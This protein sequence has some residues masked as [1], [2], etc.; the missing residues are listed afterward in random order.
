MILTSQDGRVLTVELDRPQQLN[1]LNSRVLLRLH[2]TI[3][4]AQTDASVGCIVIR[5]AGDRA[6]S[7]G[8]DLDE[9]R[10]LGVVAAQEFIQRGHRTMSS[11]ATSRV[12]VIAHVDGYALGG[13]FELALACHLAVATDRSRFGLPEARIGCMPGFGGTQRL[14]LSV[15]KPVAMHLLLSGEPIDAHRAWQIGLLSIPPLTVDEATAEVARLAHLIA[16]GSRTGLANILDAAH[17]STMPAGCDHEA[18][19][20]ALCIA[21]SDGQEGILSFAERR[22]PIFHEERR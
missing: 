15:S 1:A 4:A 5:G 18:A 21:S 11:V 20:A 3:A 19:L 17:A 12:P 16:S 6:F 7:A 8:A 14:S 22:P 10:G 2:E 13:G 9:I